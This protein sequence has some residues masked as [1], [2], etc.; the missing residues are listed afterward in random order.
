MGV[1]YVWTIRRHFHPNLELEWNE[2][3][4]IISLFFGFNFILKV[5][6]FLNINYFYV[7]KKYLIKNY[8]FN[9]YKTHFSTIYLFISTIYLFISAFFSTHPNTYIETPLPY[10]L[11]LP[12]QT[13][14]FLDS[15]FCILT[16][17][18]LIQTKHLW[19]FSIAFIL[20]PWLSAALLSC[21]AACLIGSFINVRILWNKN[22]Y[23]LTKAV[24]C[25]LM[26]AVASRM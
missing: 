26:I 3:R 18:H 10:L 12:F 17:S 24:M 19:I 13:T 8:I 6:F 7:K 15:L 23:M 11:F 21:M 25:L 16:I 14:L 20:V 1:I 4:V 22:T 2:K 9:Y 5:Y